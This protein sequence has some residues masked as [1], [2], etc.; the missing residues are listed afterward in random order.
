MEPQIGTGITEGF[1]SILTCAVGGF[2]ARFICEAVGSDSGDM[3]LCILQL[4]WVVSMLRSDSEGHGDGKS[5][6]D[7][8]YIS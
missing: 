2:S 3:G 1:T 6:G 7:D 4:H 5:H 8:A